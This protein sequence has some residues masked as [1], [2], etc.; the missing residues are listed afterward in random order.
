[1]AKTTRQRKCLV[2]AETLPASDLIRFVASPDGYI[3]PDVAAKLPRRGCWVK[4]DREVIEEA[5]KKKVFFR[6]GKQLLKNVKSD[7][8]EIEEDDNKKKKINVKVSDALAEQIEELLHKRAL[9]Y[10]GLANRAGN[11]ISGF[12]K[13]RAALKGGKATIL[14][15]ASDAAENGRSKMCQG[16]MNLR[17]IDCFT[18]DELSQATGLPNAVHI[19]LLP[20]GI[21]TSLKQEI[22]RFERIRKKVF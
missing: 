14:L 22:T 1:V 2:T 19:A 21:T 11:L 6:V 4:A 13:V 5:I 18:R 15:T 3:V 20:G 17:V 16:L 12:E 10:V 9:D 8:E 7:I